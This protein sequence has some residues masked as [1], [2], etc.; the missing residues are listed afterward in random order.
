MTKETLEKANYLLEQIRLMEE[1]REILLENNGMIIGEEGLAL[2]ATGYHKDL[3]REMAK[4][5]N[6]YIEK[7]SKQLKAM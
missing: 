5:V 3:R 4:T 2:Y 1:L 7:F 6:D